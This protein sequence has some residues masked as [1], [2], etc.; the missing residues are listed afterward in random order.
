MKVER[1]RSAWRNQQQKGGDCR[2]LS[3]QASLRLALLAAFCGLAW[4]LSGPWEV[5]R[6]GSPIF[7]R[8]L[9][10]QEPQALAFCFDVALPISDSVEKR[11]TRRVEQVI[12]KLPKNAPR[13]IFVFEFNPRTGTAGEGSSYGD[14]LD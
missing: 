9:S 1:M 6:T 5:H 14:A 8:A 13:P 3:T 2:T 11:V 12:A 7:L 10:A 4:I